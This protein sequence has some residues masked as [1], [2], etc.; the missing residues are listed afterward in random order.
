[1]GVIKVPAIDVRD[2]SKYYKV[3]DQSVRGLAS[4]SL[5]IFPGQLC[6]LVGVSGSGKSTMLNVLAGTVAVDSGEVQVAGLD[7]TTA[8]EAA[9]SRYRRESISMIYQE[10]N[11]LPMLRA[12]EN[13]ALSGYLVNADAGEVE[14]AARETLAQ[15]GLAAE[16][17][18]YPAE[19][20]G[21]QRQRVAI[22][23]A[24]YGTRV[25]GKQVLL[26]DEPSGSLDVRATD[27]VVN[28]LR[29]AADSGLA[30]LVST[31]DPRVTEHVDKVIEIRDGETA[32]R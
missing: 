1:M 29:T 28:A 24:V 10:Y 17:D 15:F 31:H 7:L 22:A 4:A 26:A 19:L 9:L 18:R 25:A 20:S 13:V 32:A 14:Q 16:V 3:G 23:R 8:D 5:E 12:W 27:E 2:V 21:G 11:L 6:A 30:V